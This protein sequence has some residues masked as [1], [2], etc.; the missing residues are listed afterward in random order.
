MDLVEET[1][2][3]LLKPGRRE[4]EPLEASRLRFTPTRPGAVIDEAHRRRIA[5]PRPGR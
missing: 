3:T 5:V 4:G 1:T 2:I